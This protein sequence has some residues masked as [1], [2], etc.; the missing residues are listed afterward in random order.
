MVPFVMLALV[1]GVR[2]IAKWRI[3][4]KWP[5]VQTAG[6]GLLVLGA[7][8][9]AQVQHGYL[10]GGGNYQLYT[11]SDHD[12]QAAT[13]IAQIPA[14]AKVA[15]QDKLDPHV[16]GRP[17]VYIFP[18]IDDADTVFVDVTGP[19]WPQHPNDLYTTV[20]TL[21]AGDFGVAAGVD[22]YLLLRKG[23]PNKTMPDT[24]YSAF[25]QPNPV[26]PRPTQRVSN[27]GE[28][29]TLL[30][31]QVTIDEHGETV[32]QLFW[33]PFAPP[34]TE[35]YH[36]YIA[37]ADAEGN[38]LQES[39]FYPPVA[40]L[41]YPT[42]M[43]QRDETILMQT[44]PWQLDVDQFTLL[45]GVYSG[46][47][48]QSG[49]RLPLVTGPTPA[50]IHLEND[51]LVRVAGYRR[52]TTGWQPIKP[53]YT[54]PT[55]PLQVSFGKEQTLVALYGV[56]P[57]QLP[58]QGDERLRFQ[59]HWWAS[60]Y[61]IDFD[62]AVFAHVLNEADEKVAQLDWQ[63]HDA[64]GPRPMTTWFTATGL[65]DPVTITLPPTLP[66]GN[67]RVILGVYN[68]QNGERLTATAD[69]GSEDHVEGD[70]VTLLHFMLP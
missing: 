70:V 67:Y 3:S 64:L 53:D 24:F 29:L 54:E 63:P 7:A 34:I 20:Q 46:E 8:I 58:T 10:P 9:Y 41:W 11:V 62:Y 42:S 31:Q 26:T 69:A 65:V 21:L 57:I 16:A 25:R 37:Y 35:D 6:I 4:R 28:A 14:D 2:R 45:V 23:L 19:A 59:L 22:G 18:R 51:T 43:W 48:W 15:A 40:T 12:R 5:V 38:I 44:L 33:Q 36:F 30:D 49:Q 13:I 52:T 50:Q 55:Q 66:A 60:R 47:S 39:T 32:V 17:T 1:E 68:W 56:T 27:F 61:G